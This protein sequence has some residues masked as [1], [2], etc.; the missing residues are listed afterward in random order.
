MALLHVAPVLGLFSPKGLRETRCRISTAFLCI[1]GH[2]GNRLQKQEKLNNNNN[3]RRHRTLN[4]FFFSCK[5]IWAISTIQLQ[6]LIS[7]VA[8][9]ATCGNGGSLGFEL[10]FFYYSFPFFLNWKNFYFRKDMFYTLCL[11]QH[12]RN[13]GSDSILPH[14]CR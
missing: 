12:I 9:V 10:A 13:T 1:H 7:V 14:K 8:S 5:A 4:F 6:K 11:Q 2:G 3:K